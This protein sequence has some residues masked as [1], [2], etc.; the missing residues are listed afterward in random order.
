MSQIKVPHVYILT[1]VLE[2]F[3]VFFCLG[4]VGWGGGGGGVVCVCV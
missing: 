4:W 1:F 2:F 3:V